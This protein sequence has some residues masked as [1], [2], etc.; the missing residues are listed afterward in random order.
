MRLKGC[1][2]REVTDI[3]ECNESRCTCPFRSFASCKCCCW[4]SAVALTTSAGLGSLGHK[5]LKD[6][7]VKILRF[8]YKP[9]QVSGTS[10]QSTNVH[11][12]HSKLKTIP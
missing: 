5:R 6:C 1:I 12:V 4:L 7:K 11:Y 9:R 2:F 3:V 8:Y 10:Q